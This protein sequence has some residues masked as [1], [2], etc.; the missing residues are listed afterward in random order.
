MW[1]KISLL[2]GLVLFSFCT[3][4]QADAT[5]QF[6]KR[7]NLEAHPNKKIDLIVSYFA[8]PENESEFKKAQIARRVLNYSYVHQDKIAEALALKEISF[9]YLASSKNSEGLA[10]CLKALKIA[11]HENNEKLI[12]Y[13]NVMLGFF[14]PDFEKSFSIYQKCLA[15]ANKIKDE[16]LKLE[17]YKNMS[18][19]CLQNDLVKEALKYSQKEYELSL[20]IR[21]FQD[22][23]YTYLSFAEVHKKLKNNDLAIGYYNTAINAAKKIN[24]KRQL[25][26]AFNYKGLFFLENNELDSAKICAQKAIATFEKSAQKDGALTGG[27]ILLDIYRNTNVD[28]AFKYSEKLRIGV[29]NYMKESNFKEQFNLKL[30]EELRQKSLT[31]EKEKL[32]EEKK[33]NIQY[34]FITIGILI[35]LTLYLL[36]SKSLLVSSKLLKFIGII[37]LLIVFEFINLLIHPFLEKITHHSPVLILLALVAIAAV[38]VPLHH[39]VEH[40]LVGKLVEKNKLLKMEKALEST[41]N[42]NPTTS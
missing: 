11:E 29:L 25:G 3:F 1:K 24:S 2:F 4:A 30:N 21:R 36:I 17:A 10:L 31:E 8:L 40:V 14:E 6:L 7:V 9:F 33:Q 28:S 27:R 22:M 42:A 13:V 19:L 38:L 39:K 32:E 23:G 26:W 5:E 15:I 41:Q 35:L 34:T 18:E 37:S 16:N 12:G 20:K